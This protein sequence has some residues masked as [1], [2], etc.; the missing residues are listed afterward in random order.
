MPPPKTIVWGVTLAIL[1][2]QLL[3]DVLVPIG[4]AGVLMDTLAISYAIQ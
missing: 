1:R 3:H 4:A 2:N